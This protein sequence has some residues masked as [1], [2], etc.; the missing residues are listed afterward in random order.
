MCICV[1][2]D[3]RWCARVH[4]CAGTPSDV[5]DL[6]A[7]VLIRSCPNE[8]TSR[9]CHLRMMPHQWSGNQAATYRADNEVV[10]IVLIIRATLINFCFLF[11]AGEL[12]DLWRDSHGRPGKVGPDMPCC[13]C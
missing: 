4:V 11:S 9:S 10:L 2:V 1:G 7:L 13:D 12:R 8:L 3:V 5:R 6:G